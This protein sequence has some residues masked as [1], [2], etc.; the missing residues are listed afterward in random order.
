MQRRLLTLPA[1]VALSAPAVAQWQDLGDTLTTSDRVSVGTAGNESVLTVNDLGNLTLGLTPSSAAIEVHQFSLKPAIWARAYQFGYPAVRG[2]GDT[3]A[4]EGI[5]DRGVGVRGVSLTENDLG[6]IGVEG[7]TNARVGYSGKFTGGR[8]VVYPDL[9]VGIN[10]DYQIDHGDVLSIDA[11]TWNDGG[12]SINTTE[13]TGQPYYGYAVA[14]R[15]VARHY[16]T[17]IDRQWRLWVNGTRLV[18]EHTNGYVGIGTNHPQ[19]RLHVHGDAGKPGG[20]SW[21]NA[22][23]ER[24]KKNV[25][26]IDGA[27]DRLLAIRGVTYEYID[28]EAIDELDGVRNGVIAQEVEA[29]FPDWVD[30]G[31]DG[32][33]RVT[34]RG[35]EGVAIEALREL[36]EE[37]DEL[38]RR[39]AALE[40]IVRER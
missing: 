38:R 8:F 14:E 21:S 15:T 34:F 10:R 31:A 25:A 3:H 7:I 27:L 26:P 30:E 1:F 12:M 35:F 11:Q 4:I 6:S 24:L 9:C 2:E 29:S 32:Y 16:Y 33:K 5:A 23:D 18:V 39:L 40:R 37:N 20:C 22:S 17:P 36:R 19:Y 28:P 13:V